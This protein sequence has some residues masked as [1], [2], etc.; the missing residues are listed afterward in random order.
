MNLED[1]HNRAVDFI[2]VNKECYV[3]AWLLQNKDKNIDDYEI[4]YSSGWDGVFR[5]SL[6]RKFRL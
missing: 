4:V 1:I 6:A 5:M 3:A 2:A